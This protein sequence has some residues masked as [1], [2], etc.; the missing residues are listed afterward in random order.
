M[1]GAVAI[2]FIFFIEDGGLETGGFLIAVAILLFIVSR[3]AP[4]IQLKSALAAPHEVFIAHN[5]IIYE[6]AVYPFRSFMMTMNRVS[7][8][9]AKGK[10]V[11]MLTFSFT[12]LVGAFIIRPFDVAVP[13]PTGE[14][15]KA[16]SVIHVL[17]G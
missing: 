2:F 11:S 12:Q 13:V 9:K 6:G 7:L 17:G 5:G 1:L 15:D 8:Q 14:E 10:D 4:K 16:D 3:I